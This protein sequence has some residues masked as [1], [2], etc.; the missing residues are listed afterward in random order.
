M[1]WSEKEY[2]NKARLYIRRAQSARADE[3]L[4]P[5]WM[6]LAMEFVARAALSKVSPVLNADPNQVDNIYYGGL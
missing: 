2:W 3:G 1:M 5:F 6:A 4:Y